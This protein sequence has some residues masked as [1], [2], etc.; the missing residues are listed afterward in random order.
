M[1]LHD[2]I[3]HVGSSSSPCWVFIKP[4]LGLHQL[5]VRIAS[6]LK[7]G[8]NLPSEVRTS[9]CSRISTPASPPRCKWAPEPKMQCAPQQLQAAKPVQQVAHTAVTAVVLHRWYKVHI[10]IEQL[11]VPKQ[12]Q[13][14]L[15]STP[16]I[17]IRPQVRQRQPCS[18]IHG[19]A[20]C[21]MELA[22]APTCDEIILAPVEKHAIRRPYVAFLGRGGVL[23]IGLCR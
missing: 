8:C 15:E 17:T 11:L 10:M 7:P 12:Q 3:L 6:T 23:F 1:L 5:H 14:P 2:V 16:F 20:S 9:V 4:V 21:K 13:Q 18:L 22:A 19:N